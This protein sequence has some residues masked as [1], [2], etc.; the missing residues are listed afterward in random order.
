[1]FPYIWNELPKGYV[2]KLIELRRERK[3]KEPPSLF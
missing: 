2:V 1:M 3:A